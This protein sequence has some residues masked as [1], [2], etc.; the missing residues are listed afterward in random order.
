MARKN[1]GAAPQLPDHSPTI[2]DAKGHEYITQVREYKLITPLFGGGVEPCEA[3]P[4]TVVRATEVRGHLRFWWRATRG[5]Q[6]GGDLKNMKAAEDRLWGAASTK[7]QASPSLVQ[8]NTSAVQRGDPIDQMPG[9]KK[10]IFE[11]GSPYS[12]AAF[13][14]QESQG[15]VRTN[16]SFTLTIT[17][18]KEYHLD[19]EAALWAWETFGGIGARTRRGF[20]ALQCVN[21]ATITKKSLTEDDI[22]TELKRHL[23][24]YVVDGSWPQDV[25]HLPRSSTMLRLKKAD[26]AVDAWRNLLT[27]LKD[28]RQNRRNNDKGKPYGRS[29]WPEPEAIRGRTGQR[30]PR[31]QPIQGPDKFPR[32]VFG[33]PIVFQFK[34]RD[35]NNPNSINPNRDPRTTTLQGKSLNERRFDRLASPLIIRPYVHTSGLALGIAVI[36]QNSRLPPQGLTLKDA[37]NPNQPPI[38]THLD[39]QEAKEIPSLSGRNDV[40]IAF[41]DS[42]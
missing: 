33:L 8:I 20:G 21:P 24:H 38:Q 35:L 18:P 16:V 42:L 1:P 6:F 31:H 32:A 14:L 10:K 23:E 4:I 15:K 9:D 30:L 12:Y 27:K 25:P 40:L 5:G 28:F 7:E 3:D 22:R 41:L 11:P 37:P 26:N 29:Y 13:P 19:I 39:I 34:D 36:L 17:F 2:C